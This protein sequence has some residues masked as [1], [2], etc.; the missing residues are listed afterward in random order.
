VSG[1]SL[2]E[3]KKLKGEK[4]QKGKETGAQEHKSKVHKV[5]MAKHPATDY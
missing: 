2:A 4:R 3:W 1:L 5:I